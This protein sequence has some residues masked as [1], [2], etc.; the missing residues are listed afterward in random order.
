[1]YV[2]LAQKL[3]AFILANGKILKELPNNATYVAFSAKNQ[4]LNKETEKLLDTVKKE[5]KPVIQAFEPQSKN[6]PWKFT[7]ITA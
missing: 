7:V 4:E 3:M 5:G 2:R 6:A 1:M